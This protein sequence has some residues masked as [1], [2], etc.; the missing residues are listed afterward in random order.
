M[1]L[2]NIIT[3]EKAREQ[4]V[5]SRSIRDIAKWHKNM[6]QQNSGSA[7]ERHYRI[8]AELNRLAAKMEEARSG[9]RSN[10][11]VSG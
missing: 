5:T 6:A 7:S 9:K 2:E 4:G 11:P 1:T 10:A 8:A 3:I